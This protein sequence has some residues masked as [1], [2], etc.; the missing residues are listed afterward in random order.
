MNHKIYTY[1]KTATENLEN[2]LKNLKALKKG[3]IIHALLNKSKHVFIENN[4]HE[5]DGN[6]TITESE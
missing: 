6:K 5:T 2:I 4:P 3:V 1:D